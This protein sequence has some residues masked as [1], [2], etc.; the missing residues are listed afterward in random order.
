MPEGL[1]DLLTIQEFRDL[2]AFLMQEEVK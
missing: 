1:A 2:V